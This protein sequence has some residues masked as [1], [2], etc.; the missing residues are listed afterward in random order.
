VHKRYLITAGLLIAGATWLTAG[1]NLPSCTEIGCLSYFRADIDKSSEWEVGRFEPA[2]QSAWVAEVPD[3]NETGCTAGLYL[4]E[5]ADYQTVRPNGRG[6]P[7]ECQ[8]A[9]AEV[10]F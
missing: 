1:C 3:D 2:H 4:G 7:P 10:S 5:G 6:C 8:Q 9:E